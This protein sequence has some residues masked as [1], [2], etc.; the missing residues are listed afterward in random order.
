MTKN[1]TGAIEYL[2]KLK[3]TLE[4]LPKSISI[5]SEN[6]DETTTNTSIDR[7]IGRFES[8]KYRN[9]TSVN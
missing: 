3:Y 9:K 7:G 4:S 6:E 2:E 8:D 5:K 1:I